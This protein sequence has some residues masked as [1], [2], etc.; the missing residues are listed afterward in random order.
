MHPRTKLVGNPVHS[1]PRTH[2]RPPSVLAPP[3]PEPEDPPAPALPAPLAPPLPAPPLLLPPAPADELP[4]P[5]AA[6]PAPAFEVPPAPAVE[7]PPAPPAMDLFPP[8]DVPADAPPVLPPSVPD[9]PP[10]PLLMAVSLLDPH[11]ATAA[12]P[13]IAT[14]IEILSMEDE[15]KIGRS[16]NHQKQERCSQAISAGFP[17]E[18][19][20]SDTPCALV[21]PA[22]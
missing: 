2:A 3:F 10:P 14:A 18:W 12:A 1:T 8:P 4:P 22:N 13:M 20:A 16:F 5:V 9:D 11:A 7:L 19:C 21:A 6:P 15:E 17:R